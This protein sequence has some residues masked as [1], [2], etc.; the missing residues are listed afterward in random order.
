MWNS[1]GCLQ[2]GSPKNNSLPYTKCEFWT[3]MILGNVQQHKQKNQN[4]HLVCIES[5]WRLQQVDGF[6]SIV[7][8]FD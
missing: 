3:L 2:S 5:V 8:T 1:R 6:I 7:V 4:L